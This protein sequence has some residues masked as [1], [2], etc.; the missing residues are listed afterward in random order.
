MGE[1]MQKFCA[2]VIAG[3]VLMI[4]G[5]AAAADLGPTP[6]Y[7]ASAGV[8]PVPMISWSGAYVGLFAG[9]GWSRPD[10]SEPINAETGFFYNFGNKPYSLDADGFFGGGSLG[11]NWQTDALVFGLEGEVGYLGL[12]GS[13]IDPNGIATGTPDTTTTFKSDFYSALTGRLGL[14]MNNIL[15]YAK[16]GGALLDAKATTIDPCV[17]PPTGCGIGTLSMS[18]D[19]T[20]IGWTAGGGIEWAYAANWTTKVEYAYYDFGKLDTTGSSNFTEH[21]RQSIDVTAQTVR[22]GVNY[23]W[24]AP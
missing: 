14:P 23:R 16:G 9:Y 1:T 21:E 10:A 5:S 4:A 12:K 8:A 13:R 6:A 18:G 22:I 15:F 17:A 3:A 24:G 2:A 11:Y 19:K 20:M 7:S